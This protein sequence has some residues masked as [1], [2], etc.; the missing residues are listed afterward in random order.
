MSEQCH[1]YSES[2][3]VPIRQ[4]GRRYMRCR[5]KAT[6]T[7]DALI[8]RGSGPYR[9]IGVCGVHGKMHDKGRNVFVSQSRRS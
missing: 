4:G 3:S 2:R 8:P 6:R 1:A 7:V 9:P 5:H